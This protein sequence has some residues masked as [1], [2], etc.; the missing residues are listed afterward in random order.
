MP[1]F[2][3]GVK[4]KLFRIHVNVVFILIFNTI[5]IIVVLKFLS[6]NSNKPYF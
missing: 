5:K 1:G 6:V 4:S 3:Y 2:F